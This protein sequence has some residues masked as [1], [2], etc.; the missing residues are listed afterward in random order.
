MKDSPN[1]SSPQEKIGR[2]ILI[3]AQMLRGYIS[4]HISE[5][6]YV[7]VS[8]FSHYD[9]RAY[10]TYSALD[11]VEKTAMHLT[12]LE[13]LLADED[14]SPHEDRVSRNAV[15]SIVEEI[16]ARSRRLIELLVILVLFSQT[17]DQD[18][19]RHMLLLL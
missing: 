11:E 4:D 3:T 16:Q 1:N 2:I 9:S 8:G 6:H 10:V 17:N 18:N 19:F 5:T 15:L 7:R 13:E 12:R 14:V